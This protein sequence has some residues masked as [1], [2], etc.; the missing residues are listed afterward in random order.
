MLTRCTVIEPTG[1][2]PSLIEPTGIELIGIEPTGI[3]P[4]GIEPTGAPCSPT[5]TM[6]VVGVR[7]V[8]D[9]QLIGGPLSH[10]HQRCSVVSLAG[11]PVAGGT[12]I[13][14]TGVEPSPIA[15]GV[16][17]PSALRLRLIDPTGTELSLVATAGVVAASAST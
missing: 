3:E 16:S 11:S 6:V 1:M 10:V 12:G 9:R 5:D 14:P 17:E 2:F 7:V 13:E 15:A 4:T 8:V